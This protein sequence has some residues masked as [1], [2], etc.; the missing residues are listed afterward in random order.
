MGSES[1]ED[2]TKKWGIICYS[3]PRLKTMTELEEE[4]Y[5]EPDSQEDPS[6]EEHLILRG[7]D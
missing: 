3:S 6:E 7:L 1:Q 4:E 2:R 5:Q